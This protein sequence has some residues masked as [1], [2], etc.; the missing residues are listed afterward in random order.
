MSLP[1][2]QIGPE[3]RQKIERMDPN[4]LKEHPIADCI[5]L[6]NGSPD[7]SSYSHVPP[8]VVDMLEAAGERGHPLSSGYHQLLLLELIAHQKARI[9]TSGLPA[10][11]KCWYARNFKRIA[12]DAAN[13][14]QPPGF[15]HFRNDK[16]L[17]DLGVCNGRI[18]PAGAQKLNRYNL[19]LGALRHGGIGQLV[20]A[21]LCVVRMGGLG[22]VY[23]MHTDSHDP[24]LMSEFSPQGWRDFY[25]NVAELMQ[26][27][28]DV[29]GLFGIGWFFDPQVAEISP[30]LAYLRDLVHESGGR[31][32]KVGANE[33][34]RESAL[35][36][37]PTRRRLHEEGRYLPTDYMALW[38]RR[39]LLRWAQ[40]QGGH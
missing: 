7:R 12:D 39:A 28:R 33:G 20:A 6:L 34:A 26:V 30:R 23:D 17:K 27:Q 9:A 13:D 35:A 24:E 22:P 19:P 3:L 8:K 14:R 15:Y 18:I 1:L 32:I 5:R 10:S 31:I 25:R 16:Y 40:T 2:P 4:R 21:A 38:D 37:S 36:T 11:I 29:R